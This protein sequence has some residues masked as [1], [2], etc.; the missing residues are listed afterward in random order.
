MVLRISDDCAA[1][2]D[3]LGLMRLTTLTSVDVVP[4][5]H[6]SH[7]TQKQ[8]GTL[9]RFAVACAS[10]RVSLHIVLLETLRS[11]FAKPNLQAHLGVH[12]E[13][14]P[15]RARDLSGVRPK[16]PEPYQ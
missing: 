1:A 6:K 5:T 7:S 15:P 13:S 3:Q 8:S 4:S 11:R 12:L 9:L 16:L 14:K 10:F 2:F